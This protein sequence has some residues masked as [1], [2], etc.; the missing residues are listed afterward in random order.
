MA[1]SETFTMDHIPSRA[2]DN[3]GTD[4]RI[5]LVRH[6]YAAATGGH[7]LSALTNCLLV[8]GRSHGFADYCSSAACSLPWERAVSSA[9]VGQ[10]ARIISFGMPTCPGCIPP[11][12][13]GYHTGQRLNM[14]LP[15]V[16]S[17]ASLPSL[18]RHHDSECLVLLPWRSSTHMRAGASLSG[19][20]LQLSCE[21]SSAAGAQPTRE[22][23]SVRLD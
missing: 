4:H 10:C 8:E 14:G 12:I 23:R 13:A 21:T 18:L 20:A 17:D 22:G 15:S 16:R 7:L 2:V 19:R 3:L 5:P 1:D 11:L 9:N 6:V